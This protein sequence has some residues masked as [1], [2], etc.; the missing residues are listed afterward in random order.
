MEALLITNNQTCMK[1]FVHNTKYV[2]MY[3]KHNSG[4]KLQHKYMQ[5][6]CFGNTSELKD[7]VTT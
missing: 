3:R 6:K 4:K 7:L 1:I 5:K 2:V